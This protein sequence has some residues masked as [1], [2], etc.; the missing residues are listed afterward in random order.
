MRNPHPAIIALKDIKDDLIEREVPLWNF[1]PGSTY[2]KERWAVFG[3]DLYN[4]EQRALNKQ[5]GLHKINH[6]GNTNAKPSKKHINLNRE[7]CQ[8]K[9]Q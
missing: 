8:I 6:F 2:E 5:L 9:K 1:I 3:E 4:K 7:K